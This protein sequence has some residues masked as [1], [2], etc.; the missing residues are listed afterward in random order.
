MVFDEDVF[1]FA[2]IVNLCHQEQLAFLRDISVFLIILPSKIKS[3]LEKKNYV[4][5]LSKQW[6]HEN[7]NQG[8]KN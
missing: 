2:I 5:I 1:L 4:T 3:F 6:D 7:L 8:K